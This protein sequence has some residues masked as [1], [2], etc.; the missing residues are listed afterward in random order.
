MTLPDPEGHLARFN[1]IDLADLLGVSLVRVDA[2]AGQIGVEDRRSQPQC[3]RSW[4]RD[5]TVR[6]RADGGL[7]SNRDA[8]AVGTT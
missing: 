8:E 3:D 1:P 2:K 4:K 5:G 7:L 6:A